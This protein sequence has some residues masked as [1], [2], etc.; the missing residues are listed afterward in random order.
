MSQFEMESMLFSAGL[1][2]CTIKVLKD[3]ICSATYYEKM[4]HFPLTLPLQAISCSI[5]FREYY[6]R[7]WISSPVICINQHYVLEAHYS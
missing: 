4:D 1:S 6:A 7:K 2:A 3:G 5:I